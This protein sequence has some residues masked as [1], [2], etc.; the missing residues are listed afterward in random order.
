MHLFSENY[1][2]AL[3]LYPSDDLEDVLHVMA[4]SKY[5][6]VVLFVNNWLHFSWFW[7][8]EEFF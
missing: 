4:L 6:M 1:V 7:K 2:M 3:W 8:F 5:I